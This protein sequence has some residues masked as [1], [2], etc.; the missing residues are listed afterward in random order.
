MFEYHWISETNTYT[1]FS[2]HKMDS[3]YL[4]IHYHQ[5]DEKTWC[6]IN[7]NINDREQDRKSVV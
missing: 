6:E 1:I 4:Q 5:D 3:Y 7:T 2:H